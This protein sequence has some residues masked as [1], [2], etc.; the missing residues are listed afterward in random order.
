MFA[1]NGLLTSTANK[2]GGW[3]ID[4]CAALPMTSPAASRAHPNTDNCRNHVTQVLFKKNRYS[5]DYHHLNT[6]S[7]V[8]TIPASQIHSFVSPLDSA[9]ITAGITGNHGK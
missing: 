6:F 3:Y 7:L 5:Q 4:A 8:I 1:V 2:A 9:G